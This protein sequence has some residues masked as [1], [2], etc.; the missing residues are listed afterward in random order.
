VAAIRFRFTPE[1]P[2]FVAVS[3]Q[4]VAIRWFRFGRAGNMAPSTPHLL[5][6]SRRTA[7]LQQIILK[8]PLWVWP[9][10]AYLIYRGILAMKD[11]ESS[12]IRA[13]IIPVA[14]LALSLQGILS[15]FGGAAALGA[16]AAFLLI[17]TA[18]SRALVDP[19]SVSADP[20]RGTVTQKGSWVPLALMMS[21]FVTKY[22]VNIA[23]AIDAGLRHEPAFVI[24][25]SALYGIFNGVFA[26]R[27][28]RTV[29]AY[30]AAQDDFRPALAK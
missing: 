8:T 24:A 6:Y 26:G 23:L 25:I 18:A 2:R 20:Q 7:M 10:L 27:L 21:I 3:A 13:A 5:N 15:T 30:R 28:L 4:F 1:N 17:G 9:L 16:W 29:A 19:A 11:R 12:M 22:A 14:M